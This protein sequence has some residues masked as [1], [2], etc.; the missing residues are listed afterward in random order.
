MAGSSGAV[1]DA[2]AGEEAAEEAV[3]VWTTEEGVPTRLVWRSR[4][5]RVSDRPTVWLAACPWWRP[6][7]PHR[8]DVGTVPRQ[9]EGWRFQATDASGDARVFDVRKSDGSGWRLVRVYE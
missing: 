5:Y 9:I 1:A 3:A 8:Y 6:F 2:V 4:R 7:E